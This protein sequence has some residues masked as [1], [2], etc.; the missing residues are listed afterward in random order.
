MDVLLEATILG[1]T[2][3]V[4]CFN[5][6]CN[7]CTSRRIKYRL[8]GTEV[9]VS[10]LIVMDVLLEVVVSVCLRKLGTWFQSLL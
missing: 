5:P 1:H 10:I 7:G 3:L 6:Y 4:L 9:L 2:P 8:F